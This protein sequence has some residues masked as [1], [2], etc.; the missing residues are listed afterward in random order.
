M[1]DPA[2]KH[3]RTH[4]PGRGS[5]FV[6]F[7]AL[8][9][10]S[11]FYVFMV[12]AMLAADLWYTTPEHFLA[13]LRS[14]EI[15]YSILLSLFS[16]NVTAILSV[17]VAVPTAYVMTRFKFPGKN[18]LDAVLD[19]PVVLPPLVVGLSLLILFRTAPGRMLED[20]MERVVGTRFTYEIPGVILAQ[21]MVACAFAIRTMRA[22]L[23]QI[24]TRQEQVGHTLGASSWQVFRMI[25]LPQAWRGILTAGAIAW[26]RALGEFGPILVFAGATRH[27]TEVLST[28]VFLHLTVGEI[29]AAVAV[30][31][32]MVVIAFIVLVII[33]QL[34]HG[35]KPPGVY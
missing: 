19:A 10:L 17:I 25:V 14:S 6:F 30:T 20:T 28:T 11:G 8:F 4:A 23:D 15:Q 16:C 29:E 5:N 9:L 3:A 2:P 18:V 7:A 31:V 32:L 12:V 26:A 24:S 21:F 27:R 13:A 35:E 34:G 33:R 22:T 1:P